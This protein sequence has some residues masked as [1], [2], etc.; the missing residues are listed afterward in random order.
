MTKCYNGNIDGHCHSKHHATMAL[1]YCQLSTKPA[2]PLTNKNSEAAF[3]FD[4]YVRGGDSEA[5]SM[6]WSQ[7]VGGVPQ[8]KMGGI[9]FSLFHRQ[10][11][12]AALAPSHA[13]CT[14]LD[15]S[16]FSGGVHVFNLHLQCSTVYCM[17]DSRVKSI[18]S[19]QLQ[20]RAVQF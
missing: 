2:L 14:I 9:H 3:R 18:L 15:E 1:T 8:S 10:R 13:H 12:Q 17:H 4:T 19:V 20:Y 7:H 6:P 16:C 11:G 5:Q